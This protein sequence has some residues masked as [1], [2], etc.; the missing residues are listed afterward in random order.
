MSH[1]HVERLVKR[2]VE[3]L[4]VTAMMLL[5]PWGANAQAKTWVTCLPE[6]VMPP[7]L[8]NDA[9]HPGLL[10][11]LM[12]AAGREVGVEVQ[13]QHFPLPRCMALLERN[14][15]DATIGAPTASVGRFAHFPAGAAKADER[16]A[17][18]KVVLVARAGEKV[19]L[20]GHGLPPDKAPV[21]GVRRRTSTVSEPLA[22]MGYRIDQS[23]L[24]LRQSLGM[25]RLG[26]VD[27]VAAIREELE[28]EIRSSGMEGLTVVGPPVLE[29][30]YFAG[31]SG[32]LWEA[33]EELVK[34]WWAAMGRLRKLREFSPR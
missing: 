8:T 28:A 15:V 22:A 3:L 25:L 21:V 13:V 7:Y 19:H 29:I 24:N 10:A 17:H 14:Q 33:D 9:A 16:I 18:V 32:K 20:L 31:V 34:R 27:L 30:D 12:V 23:T 11:R 5:T 4:T 26:R 2:A 1:P 6:A